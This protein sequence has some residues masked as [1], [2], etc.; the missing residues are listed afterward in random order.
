MCLLLIS[1][2][3][4][5]HT[6]GKEVVDILKLNL[7]LFQLVEDGMNGLCTPLDVIFQ[8]GSV[9]PLLYRFN[10]FLNILLA[11]PFCLIQLLCNKIVVFAVGIFQAE[12]L[13]LRISCSCRA[14]KIKTTLISSAIESNRRI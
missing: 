9:E 14:I 7:L 3:I 8:S 13:E 11:G 1:R 4:E 12:V 5:Y 2:C 10:K 6:D